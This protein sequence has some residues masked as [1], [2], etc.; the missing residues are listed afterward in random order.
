MDEYEELEMTN[1]VKIERFGANATATQALNYWK[2]LSDVC[3]LDGLEFDPL[4]DTTLSHEPSPEEL[5]PHPLLNSKLRTTRLLITEASKLDANVY[6]KFRSN[7]HPLPPYPHPHS[8]PHCGGT[9]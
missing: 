8:I 4:L 7:F 1:D 6:A 2:Q 9:Y 5:P 3:R